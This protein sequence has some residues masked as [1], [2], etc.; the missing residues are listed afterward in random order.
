MTL[1][2]I[3]CTHCWSKCSMSSVSSCPDQTIFQHCCCIFS[4]PT[5]L[6][7]LCDCE[8]VVV[9]T[10]ECQLNG[11]SACLT[12]AG[13]RRGQQGGWL[14]TATSGQK[15][16]TWQQSQ[17]HLQTSC[18]SMGWNLCTGKQYGQR[19]L[20]DTF[21]CLLMPFDLFHVAL[22]WPAVH[23]MLCCVVLCCAALQSAKMHC[24]VLCDGLHF[25]ALCTVL[26]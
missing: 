14:A 8:L 2:A 3:L 23:K 13:E 16:S 4:K 18:S 7:M 11:P 10:R 9:V 1:R 20:Y 15:A 12:V 25:A 5:N 17:K 19:L 26:Y 6:A 22:P 24:A 21:Y